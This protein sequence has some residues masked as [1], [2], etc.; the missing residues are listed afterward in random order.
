MTKNAQT[1]RITKQAPITYILFKFV[2]FGILTSVIFTVISFWDGGSKASLSVNTVLATAIIG[3]ALYTTLIIAFSPSI[4]TIITSLIIICLQ[5]SSHKKRTATGE[6]LIFGDISHTH[7]LSIVLNYIE[8]KQ[9][10]IAVALLFLFVGYNFVYHFFD[11]RRKWWQYFILI[12]V[13]LLVGININSITLRAAAEAQNR[14]ITY[15]S[16]DWPYNQKA[17]GLAIHLIQ[18]G[19]RPLPVNITIK[20][21]REYKELVNAAVPSKGSPQTFIMILCESCWYDE[22]TFKDIFE[23]LARNADVVLRGVSSEY[24]GGTPNTTFEFVT[25][26]PARN[27][28]ISGIVYQEYR[29]YLS[30]TTSTLPAHLKSSGFRTES[31]HNYSKAF[32]FRSDV[33]PKLGFDRFTGIED[34]NYKATDHGYPPDSVLFNHTL[35]II[36]ENQG[37]KKL[38]MH[39]ATM[40]THG[41]YLPS[42]NDYGIKSYKEKLSKS[43]QSIGV[44]V[45]E[46]RRID[47]DAVIFIY[48]DHK[49]GLPLL[50]RFISDN[51]HAQGDVPILLFDTDKERVKTVQLELSDKPFYCMSSSL[52]RIYFDMK[53]PA[54]R[55]TDA[56][57]QTYNKAKYEL[58][59]AAIPA[60]VYS[61]ALFDR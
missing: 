1:K 50:S 2:A 46:V 54:S 6:P 57:C 12:C 60:W 40:Y 36:K 31:I 55:Y 33:E 15:Y 17:N 47:P 13:L 45:N 52:S 21:R 42:D 4:S 18:T 30:S 8:Y 26:L 14:G 9:L 34:I 59:S 49:P 51:K 41:P 38:F 27:P 11:L 16:W 23:P 39:L 53:L 22:N 61:A 32:W 48:G 20:Q 29:D 3:F 24:G 10:I 44:F 35:S 7:H 43:L 25:G 56:P 5:I 28:A 37:S 58:S 19:N